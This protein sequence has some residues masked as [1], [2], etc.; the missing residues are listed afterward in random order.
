MRFIFNSLRD[1]FRIW[2]YRAAFLRLRI[3][4]ALL[5]IVSESASQINANLAFIKKNEK[6]VFFV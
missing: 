1:I 5:I 3:T 4:A 2:L 6:K